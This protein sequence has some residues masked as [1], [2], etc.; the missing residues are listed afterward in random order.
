VATGAESTSW[1]GGL[2]RGGWSGRSSR[3]VILFW[4]R[5]ARRVTRDVPRRSDPSVSASA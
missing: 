4:C 1:A 5:C 2:V 3:S